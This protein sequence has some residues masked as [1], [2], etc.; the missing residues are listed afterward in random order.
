MCKVTQPTG[1]CLRMGRSALGIAALL[2]GLT[3]CGAA[4][5]NL[6]LGRTRLTFRDA[7][8]VIELPSEFAKYGPH[9]FALVEP[10]QLPLVRKASTLTY[11]G[12]KDGFHFFITWNKVVKEGEV[13]SVALR[14][15]DCAVTRPRSIDDEGAARRRLDLSSGSC[16]VR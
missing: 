10:A 11:L 16:V 15:D 5:D 7:Q 8:G 9:R 6:L 2:L 14:L 12:T 1:H 13:A 4:L 3:G